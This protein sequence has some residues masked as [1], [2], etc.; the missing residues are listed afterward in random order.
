MNL[1]DKLRA[2]LK[3]ASLNR[4]ILKMIRSA[5]NAD[6]NEI[7]VLKRNVDAHLQNEDSTPAGTRAFADHLE[8]IAASR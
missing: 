3:F 7:E 2:E 4:D 5:S 6:S 1:K 8:G